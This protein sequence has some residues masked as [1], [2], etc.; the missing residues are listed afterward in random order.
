MGKEAIDGHLSQIGGITPQGN[1]ARAEFGTG[2]TLQPDNIPTIMILA[3]NG[4]LRSAS[5]DII[6]RKI[7][8]EQASK[9][10][11]VD[12]D[13]LSRKSS[14]V[15]K[16]RYLTYDNRVLSFGELAARRGRNT[17]RQALRDVEEA[18]FKKLKEIQAREEKDRER[19]LGERARHLYIIKEQSKAEI[20]QSLK[21]DNDRLER[22]MSETDTHLREL[23]RPSKSATIN[24][25]D[26]IRYIIN[27]LREQGRND[28]EIGAM[29][30]LTKRNI[31][32][33]MRRQ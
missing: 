15:I 17:S 20:A 25:P 27:Y 22:L 13:R 5:P 21:I 29:L 16:E 30:K 23:G 8:V 14:G 3:S 6:R 31:R 7:M 19:K 32:Y 10:G 4:I 24:D 33:R 9:D 12:L 18:E 2:I 11:Y 26:L 28:A 1:A